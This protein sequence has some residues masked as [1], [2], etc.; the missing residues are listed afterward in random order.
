MDTGRNMKVQEDV[1]L[2]EIAGECFLIPT[3]K[4]VLKYNGLLHVSPLEAEL[5]EMLRQGTNLEELVQT[6]MTVYDVQENALRED[7][8]EFL[9][10]LDGSG[11]L[12]SDGE[13]TG[14]PAETAAAAG[15][16]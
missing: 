10:R 5:W 9:D 7:I 6:M 11:I 12:I 2:R 8:Q 16:K 4:T 15:E 14:V 13:E 3:G 1:V